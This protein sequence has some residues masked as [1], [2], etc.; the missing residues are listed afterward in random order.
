MDNPTAEGRIKV[1]ITVY[2]ETALSQ[3]LKNT[4]IL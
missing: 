1:M 4:G 3:A 2:S